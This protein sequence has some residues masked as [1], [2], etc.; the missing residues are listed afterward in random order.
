MSAYAQPERRPFNPSVTPW[1][2]DSAAM[3]KLAFDLN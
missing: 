2:D 1:G 3:L